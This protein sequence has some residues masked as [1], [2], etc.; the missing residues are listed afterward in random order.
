MNKITINYSFDHENDTIITY[1]EDGNASHMT[2]S[3]TSEDLDYGTDSLEYN[4][5]P[6][7]Q[8]SVMAQD[9][10]NE[11]MEYLDSTNDGINRPGDASDGL[12][13]LY[14]EFSNST[15]YAWEGALM[16]VT[17]PT[18]T[19][20]RKLPAKYYMTIEDAAKMVAS[21]FIKDRDKRFAFCESDAEE[22]KGDPA[23]HKDNGGWHG[24]RRVDGFFDN[25]P[26]EFIV[27]V[28]HFGGGNVGFGYV[29]LDGCFSDYVRAVRHAI[30]DA[31]G[32]D[33]DNLIYIEEDK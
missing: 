17:D 30:C 13:I 32:W 20:K 6:V 26:D 11:I 33:A 7:E 2:A 16:T 18:S 27:A 21:A 4:S 8:F 1:W 23:D 5:S 24:I 19:H 3:F 22:A 12:E 14:G 25:E 10:L 29:D 28:G 9:W 31:T 15:L